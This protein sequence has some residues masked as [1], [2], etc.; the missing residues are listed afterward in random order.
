MTGRRG[1]NQKLP[2]TV[3]QYEDKNEYKKQY[4]RLKKNPEKSRKDWLKW[5]Y[6]LTSEQ[7]DELLVQQNNCCAICHTTET[8]YHSYFHVDHDHISGVIRGLLCHKCNKGLGLF[9]D[10]SEVLREAAKYLDTRKAPKTE[11]KDK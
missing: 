7:Y 11:L 1:Q 4:Y 8:G 10:N 2:I 3:S 9:Y 5:K 6:K